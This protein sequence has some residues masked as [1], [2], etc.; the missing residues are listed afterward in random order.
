ML[1]WPLQRII[2]ESKCRVLH[3]HCSC[4]PVALLIPSSA[5]IKATRCSSS[6]EVISENTPNPLTW[7]WIYKE[8]L[9]VLPRT[10]ADTQSCLKVDLLKGQTVMDASPPILDVLRRFHQ[11]IQKYFQFWCR[12]ALKLMIW[13]GISVFTVGFTVANEYKAITT[14]RER[15]GVCCA[16]L[17][18]RD[19]VGV[20]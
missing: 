7:Q 4:C 13:G 18:S 8:K 16:P 14:G 19:S 1:S 15:S 10:S 12:S 9:L 11:Q 2:T 6:A 20:C 17:G 5:K 3:L